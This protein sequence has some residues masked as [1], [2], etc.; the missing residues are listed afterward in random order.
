M[1]GASRKTE[2][3]RHAADRINRHLQK[4]RDLIRDAPSVR[5]GAR[6]RLVVARGAVVDELLEAGGVSQGG[7]EEEE[8]KG[9]TGGGAEGDVLA[10]QPGV[11]DLLDEWVEEDAGEGVD[12]F[13]GVVGDAR[14]DHLARLG[15]EVVEGLVEAEP[16]EGEK[17][18]ICKCG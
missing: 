4:Y 9:D 6:E 14:V 12:G 8:A 10:A 7:R 2:H 11:D 18:A 15:D 3:L 16:V 13:D 17:E 5:R 1:F